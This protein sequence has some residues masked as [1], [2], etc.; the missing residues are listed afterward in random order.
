MMTRTMKLWG[1]PPI[2]KETHACPIEISR[3]DFAGHSSI[4]QKLIAG[5]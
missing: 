5:N 3:V 2:K 4:K 1:L